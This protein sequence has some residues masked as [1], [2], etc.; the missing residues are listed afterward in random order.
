[1]VPRLL[2]PILTTSPPLI[3]VN[4]PLM[5]Q[6][7]LHHDHLLNVFDLDDRAAQVVRH[8]SLVSLEA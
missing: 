4:F 7:S 2:C 5:I 6:D 3:M 8:A 1:M